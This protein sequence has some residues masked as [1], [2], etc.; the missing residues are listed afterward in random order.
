MS[1][2]E[3]R[4]LTCHRGMRQVFTGLD[5]ALPEGGVLLLTGANGSGKST[6]LRIM[7]GLLRPIA[8]ALVWGGESV[9]EDPDAH[10]GRVHY[11][12]HQD[13]VK[14]VLTAAENL[15]F[16]G[17]LR[18]RTNDDV[19]EALEHFGLGHLGKGAWR[20]P[21]CWSPRASCGCSTSPVWGW[22][23]PPLRAWARRSPDTGTAAGASRRPPTYPCRS[24]AASS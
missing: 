21:G 20:W 15:A 4:D 23:T 9:T 17:G 10:R 14:P 12:G 3:G 18:G 24:T 13:A 16:W 6:L 22:T 8:G 5:F 11:L 19:T 2:F 7:A 1:L